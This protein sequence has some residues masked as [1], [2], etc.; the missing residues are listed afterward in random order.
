MKFNYKIFFIYFTILFTLR[1]A[2]DMFH[3]E[4]IVG[5]LVFAMVLSV[6][7]TFNIIK[8]HKPLS[9]LELKLKENETVQ[10]VYFVSTKLNNNSW[11]TGNLF[12][13]NCR[14]AF[15]DKRFDI[16]QQDFELVT[17]DITNVKFLKA[18]LF[19]DQCIKI[20]TNSGKSIKINGYENVKSILEVFQKIIKQKL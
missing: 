17:S 18:R 6:F 5:S 20:E 16:Q 8:K 19:Q 9:N 1:W 11:T 10:D 3:I 12:I 14:I 2:F 13:T 4:N 7:L 15:V